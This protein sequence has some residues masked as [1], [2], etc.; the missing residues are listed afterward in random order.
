MNDHAER[1]LA[2]AIRPGDTLFHDSPETGT[3]SCLCSRCGK[4]IKLA[5]GVAI[6][7]W[8][9]SGA[10]LRYHMRCLSLAPGD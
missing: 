6:R 7:V 5:D 4:V 8:P 1:K 9:K 3:K 2:M 10:E